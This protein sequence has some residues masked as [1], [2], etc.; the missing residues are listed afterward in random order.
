MNYSLAE[1]RFTDSLRGRDRS[2]ASGI[3]GHF[4]RLRRLPLRPIAVLIKELNHE[5]SQTW[6][7]IC[8][9]CGDG[10]SFRSGPVGACPPSA[11]DGSTAAANGVMDNLTFDNWTM[12]DV[13]EDTHIAKYY[14]KAPERPVQSGRRFFAT[15]QS[16][17]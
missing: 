15:S 4:D 6:G 8:C 5:Q 3:P 16:A 11:E 13:D 2:P 14:T 9:L 12:E 7:N 1:T 10:I 17:T